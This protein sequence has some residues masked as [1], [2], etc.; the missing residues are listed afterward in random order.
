[1]VC[2]IRNITSNEPQGIQRTALTPEGGR[3][4]RNGKTLRMSL[5]RTAGGAIKIDCDEHV[6][7]GVVIGEGVETCFAARQLGFAPVWSLI[8][9]SGI[10]AFPV[11]SGLDGLTIL[12]EDGETSRRDVQLC[13]DRWFAVGV[14]PEVRQ[15]KIG[16]DMND[17]LDGSP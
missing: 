7:Q 2:L 9:S 15:S 17:A 14:R 11:L 12:A 1:M 6:E 4:K 13:F 3:I 16:S 5:G 8:S 10:A